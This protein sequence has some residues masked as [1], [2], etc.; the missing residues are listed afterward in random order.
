[1]T[2]VVNSLFLA[3][4]GGGADLSHAQLNGGGQGGNWH[5]PG[6]VPSPQPLPWLE[7]KGQPLLLLARAAQTY[8]EG[9][10]TELAQ[11]Q[12]HFW[13]AHGGPGGPPAGDLTGQSPHTLKRALTGACVRTGSPHRPSE[14]AVGVAR[15]W[16]LLR[17]WG[18]VVGGL[19]QS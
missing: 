17:A 15:L 11:G 1:M 16:L 18:W 7:R 10:R 3:E 8:R 5:C 19:G 4:L 14:V 12:W 13:D 9:S 6:G 2:L